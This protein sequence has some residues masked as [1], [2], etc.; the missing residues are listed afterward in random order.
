MTNLTKQEKYN[1]TYLK[2]LLEVKLRN[3]SNISIGVGAVVNKKILKELSKEYKL[4]KE[5]FGY[6]KFEKK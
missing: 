3:H 6:W 1:L 2:K 4:T 5:L